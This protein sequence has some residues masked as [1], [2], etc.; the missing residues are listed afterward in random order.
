MTR[1]T[2]P[3]LFLLA[4]GQGSGG[5]DSG[6]SVGDGGDAGAGDDG[7]SGDG[8]ST[9]DDGGGDDTGGEEPDCSE[10]SY[11]DSGPVLISTQSE[12][13]GFCDSWNAVDGDLYLDVG[14][15]EDPIT[16]LDDIKCL[17]AV[18]GDLTITGDSSQ[19]APPEGA[20]PPHVVGDI[21]LSLLE[22]VGGDLVLSH[23][24][25]LDFVQGLV[26]LEEVGGDV[27]LRDIPNL[28][29]IKFFGLQ[30][31]GGDIV[32]EEMDKLLIMGFEAATSIGG[33]RL[34]EAGDAQSMFFLV[35]LGMGSLETV[36]G[37]LRVVGP[38]NLPLLQAPSLVTIGGALHLE[39][40]CFTQPSFAAL[41]S[42]GSLH[43]EGNCG[44]SSLAGLGSLSTVTGADD[45]GHA[46][47]I[48]AQADLDPEE[49]EAWVAGLD[50]Q[51]GEVL[52][53]LSTECAEVMADYGEGYCG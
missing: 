49:T 45:D 44:L 16:E 10:L 18:E 28:Q 32:V 46:V 27:I 2:L 51:S 9:G 31:V 19:T 50:L 43:L 13:E 48:A 6:S 42:V 14:S 36:T 41:E 17:C 15:A 5:A 39:A 4:C 37:D 40:S 23:H 26:A 35:E 24:P 3:L 20:P 30:T 34:G 53:D 25:Q 52:L 8:G 21:E 33:L 29:V 38:R 7:G 11:T 47:V 22:R 12:L 1:L